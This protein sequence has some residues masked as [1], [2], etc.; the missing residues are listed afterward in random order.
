MLFNKYEQRNDTTNVK[1]LTQETERIEQYFSQTHNVATEHLESRRGESSSIVY[2]ASQR[3]KDLHVEEGKAGERAERLDAKFFNEELANEAEKERVEHEFAPKIKELEPCPE[4]IKRHYRSPRKTSQ[5]KTKK[6]KQLSL[7]T[8]ISEELGLEAELDD[9][10]TRKT[11]SGT[12]H[13]QMV[14]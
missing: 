1:K 8:E 11:P 5:K 2:C 12:D 10:K 9:K 3:I 4:K 14:H 7:E 13:S 6:K